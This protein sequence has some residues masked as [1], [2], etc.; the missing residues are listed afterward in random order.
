MSAWYQWLRLYRIHVRLLGAFVFLFLIT[1]LLSSLLFIPFYYQQLK[2]SLDAQISQGTH[3]IIG[4]IST[5]AE[6][7]VRSHLKGITDAELTAVRSFYEAYRRGEMSEQ[8]AKEAASQHLRHIT[9]GSSGYL[10][11]IDSKGI[12]RTHIKPELIGKSLARYEFIRQQMKTKQGYLEYDWQNPGESAPRKKALYMTY[13]AP[14]DWIISA[15]SYRDEFNQ[16][17]NIDD[18]RHRILEMRFGQSGYAYVL[19]GQGEVILHPFIKRHSP[20]ADYLKNTPFV[21][22]MLEQRN[23]ALSYDWQNPDEPTP[24]EKVARFIFLPSYDWLIVSTYYVD[25]FDQ[26][27]HQLLK[28]SALFLLIL[29]G[30]IV[31]TAMSLSESIVRP[32]RECIGRVNRIGRGGEGVLIASTERARDEVMFMSR[33]FDKFIQRLSVSH[34]L[35]EENHRQRVDLQEKTEALNRELAAINQSLEVRVCERTAALNETI[36]QLEETR[37]HLVEAEK[38]AALSR[39]IAGVAHEIN[40]PLGNLVTSTSYL[41]ELMQEHS[42]QLAEGRLSRTHLTDYEQGTGEL[43]AMMEQNLQRLVQLIQRF[44]MLDLQDEGDGPALFTLGE[45]LEEAAQFSH[46]DRQGVELKIEGNGETLVKGVKKWFML[47]FSELMLNSLQHGGERLG[48]VHITITATAGQL[49]IGYGDDGK[50]I[51]ERLIP[52][53]FEPFVTDAR[54]RGNAGLGLHQ[55]YNIVTQKMGGEIRY[56]PSEGQF[57]LTLPFEESP[58]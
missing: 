37:T 27:L 5:S 17:I 50:G 40:T 45:L 47:S 24:R 33:F 52:H 55:I 30:V 41:F 13:F 48:Q 57:W 1:L 44:K 29:L 15:S 32:I 11:V 34:T 46:L 8:A 18:F 58:A 19:D 26:P 4:E 2:Q 10:Y 12:I 3:A 14:W 25:E 56:E 28:M 20:E 51:D 49:R 31:L 22:Q 6:T 21:R 23:G 42:R 36:R 54:F 9:I 35:L 53:L 16:L 39:L 38:N 43:H 7:A